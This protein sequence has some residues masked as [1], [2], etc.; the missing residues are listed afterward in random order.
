MGRKRQVLRPHHL[1]SDPEHAR[2][3]L[4]TVQRELGKA[5]ASIERERAGLAR[6][7]E[8][9]RLRTA[10]LMGNADGIFGERE[11]AADVVLDGTGSDENLR[12]QVDALWQRLEAE[13]NAE[14]DEQ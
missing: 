6:R 10:S 4:G 3:R 1:D 5:L 8:E 9:A 7:L 12:A 14:A 13:R 2:L 11:A